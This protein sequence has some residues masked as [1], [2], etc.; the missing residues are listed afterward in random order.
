LSLFAILESKLFTIW[1]QNVSSRLK[2]D[3]QISSSSVYNTF[4]FP[5]L[6]SVQI[7]N[8][9]ELAED[10]L[11][12]REKYQGISLGDLYDPILMPLELQKIHSKLDSFA[13]KVLGIKQ[14]AS[15]EDI[16]KELFN[17]YSKASDEILIE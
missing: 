4:P 8:L 16:L 5:T 15:D 1:V 7:S 6:D 11:R 17:L 3:Y 2:S 10:I 12:I 13:L 9:I 14:S